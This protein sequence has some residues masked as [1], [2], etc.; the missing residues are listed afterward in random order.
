M[1]LPLSI[2][3]EILMDAA[4]RGDIQRLHRGFACTDDRKLIIDASEAL[5]AKLLDT[6]VR[7]ATDAYAHHED[8]ILLMR[9]AFVALA[10]AQLDPAPLESPPWVVLRLYSTNP[11]NADPRALD[12]AVDMIFASMRHAPIKFTSS[13]PAESPWMDRGK[14]AESPRMDPAPSLLLYAIADCQCSEL[15]L[16]RLFDCGCAFTDTELSL[17]TALAT[18]I[19]TP[20]ITVAALHQ[21]A[22]R[23]RLRGWANA[24]IASEPDGGTVLHLVCREVPAPLLAARIH[25]L[26]WDLHV[27]PALLDKAG[28]APH[29]ILLMHRISPGGPAVDDCVRLL[30]DAGGAARGAGY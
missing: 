5:T 19:R 10:A 18:I 21:L 23:N 1:H 25:T 11:Y 24:P 12:R 22:F 7:R 3:R 27:N 28:L 15:V 30:L 4:T 17:G 20:R 13:E 8:F 6:C 2:A 14:P 16:N 26:L 9:S 29:Q